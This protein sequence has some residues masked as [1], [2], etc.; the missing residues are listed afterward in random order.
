MKVKCEG[1]E[2]NVPANEVYMLLPCRVLSRVGLE[3]DVLSLKYSV[4]AWEGIFIELQY[5]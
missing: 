4:N 3:P 5:E 1:P 2:N